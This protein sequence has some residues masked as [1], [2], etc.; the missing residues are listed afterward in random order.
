M[1]YYLNRTCEMAQQAIESLSSPRTGRHKGGRWSVY[2]RSALRP[3]NGDEMQRPEGVHVVKTK[4]RK[5]QHSRMIEGAVDRSVF[6][7]Q[8][9]VLSVQ[10][11]Y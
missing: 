3:K 10:C 4:E 11:Q 2:Y 7:V 8:C 6:S 1:Y 9:P 5:V